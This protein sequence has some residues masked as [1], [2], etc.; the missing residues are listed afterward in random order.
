MSNSFDTVRISSHGGFIDEPL[1]IYQRLEREIA[2][3]KTNHFING[4]TS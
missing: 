4:E 2:K 1:F 3:W